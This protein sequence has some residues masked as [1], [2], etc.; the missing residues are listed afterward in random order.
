MTAE[1][2]RTRV[3]ALLPSA[4]AFDPDAARGEAVVLLERDALPAAFRTL[5]DHPELRFDLLSDLS[6][7]D[8]LPRTP[9]FEV[10][11]QLYSVSLNHRLR[12]KVLLAED[13]LVV[14]TASAVWR[15][16]NWAERETFDMFGIRFAGHPDLRRILMY[17][18][19][20]GFPLRK[21]YPVARREPLIP[22]RD[23]V[24][25]PW[26]PHGGRPRGV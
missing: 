24:T 15:S 11:Y 26:Y 3:V 7:V 17:P 23:P 16:A 6:A 5:R 8:Y 25:Q 1:E 14:P 20:T 9:R 19:F 4:L 10:V 18:E 22:E 12:V 13:D 21:D 2:L